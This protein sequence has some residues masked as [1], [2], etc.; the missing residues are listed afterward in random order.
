[1]PHPEGS[2]GSGDIRDRIAAAKQEL[3]PRVR[4]AGPAAGA[5][6]AWRMV[7]DLAAGVGV[8]ACAGYGLG[9]LFGITPILLAVFTLL[10]FAAGV[11]LMLR[12]ARDFQRK[13]SVPRDQ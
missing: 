3:K 4:E 6:L 13:N 8:G 2:E 1:M 12:T 10:G 9:S 7:I 11:N 5:H